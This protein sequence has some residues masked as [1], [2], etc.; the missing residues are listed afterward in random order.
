VPTYTYKAAKKNGGVAR[1]KLAAPNEIDLEQ[2]LNEM[3]LVLLQ[4]KA[5]KEKKGGLFSKIGHK[6][7][8]MFCVHL[9]QLER[10][11]VPLLDSLA[12]LK[13]SCE[14]MKFRSVVTE[15]YEIVKGGEMLSSALMKKR[16]IFGDVF[17]GLVASGE[18]TGNMA[19]AF[20][21]LADHIKWNAEFSRKIKKAIKYPIAL[22]VVMSIVITV[23]MLFVVPQLVEFMK[24]QGFELPIY[25]RA[26]IATSALF[27][28][29]WYLI[30]GIPVLMIIGFVMLYKRN[31]RFQYVM[32]KIFL[33]VPAIGQVIL[34]MNLSRFS[35]FFAITFSSGIGIL[36]CL[37]TTKKVIGNLIIREAVSDIIQYVSE[38]TPIA[39]SIAMTD[40][41]PSLVTRMFKVG[42]ESGNMESALQNINFFYDREVEDSVE[43]LVGVI[44][45]ALVVVM[46]ILMFWIIAAVFG[47]LYSSFSKIDF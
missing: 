41:F 29:A 20:S 24:S 15:I 3:S 17:I 46:G 27:V 37:E 44:Q 23:M 2:R 26:L 33:K 8:I 42:E 12:D 14:N 30:L 34:K 7:L 40:R 39:R 4:H 6:D 36:E 38:G 18:Q 5:E 19:Q 45:P 31:E 32:D 1:G 11:G 9:E 13:D 22:L 21:A 35:R 47:P 43:N 28:D 16:D 10:A 25:T